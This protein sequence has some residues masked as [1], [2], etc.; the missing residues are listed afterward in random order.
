MPI[1]QSRG[2]AICESRH[3]VQLGAGRDAFRPASGPRGL[4]RAPNLPS[5]HYCYCAAQALS[6]HLGVVVGVDLR[7]DRFGPHGVH[8]A[9]GELESDA[10]VGEQVLEIKNDLPPGDVESLQPRRPSTRASIESATGANP[11]GTAMSRT[12][13]PASIC[14]KGVNRTLTDTVIRSSTL[15]WSVP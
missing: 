15:T 11:V 8:G 14:S 7:R 13:I 10:L 6:P 2:D 12:T 4:A 3:P 5:L 9:C 1:Y